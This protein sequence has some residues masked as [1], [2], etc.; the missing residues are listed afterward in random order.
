MK[1]LPAGTVGQTDHEVIVASIN[2]SRDVD[3]MT[4]REATLSF[5]DAVTLIEDPRLDRLGMF[6]LA[7]F[8]VIIVT[9]ALCMIVVM[10]GFGAMAMMIEIVVNLNV[11]RS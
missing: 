10:V 3:V 6:M 2:V 11:V 8:V 5:R 4:G 7:L 9:F 1:L